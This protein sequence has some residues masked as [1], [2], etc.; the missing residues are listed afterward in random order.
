MGASDLTKEQKLSQA[1][2]TRRAIVETPGLTIPMPPDSLKWRSKET[3]DY[4]IAL[5]QSLMDMQTHQ[6]QQLMTLRQ[7]KITTE[8]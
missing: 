3:Y 2:S 4:L 7:S 1:R 5:R 8:T 6:A